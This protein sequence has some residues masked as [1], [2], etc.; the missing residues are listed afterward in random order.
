MSHPTR[1]CPLKQDG[2]EDVNAIDNEYNSFMSELGGGPT[3]TCIS[4]ST[5]NGNTSNQAAPTI[6]G[7][8]TTTPQIIEAEYVDPNPKPKPV[9]PTLRHQELKL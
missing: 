2:L 3:S 7:S 4:V 9:V 6:S 5:S 8:S 1:D